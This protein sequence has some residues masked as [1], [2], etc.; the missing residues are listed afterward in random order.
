MRGATARMAVLVLVLVLGAA[1][2]LGDDPGA[3]DPSLNDPNDPGTPPPTE[4]AQADDPSEVADPSEEA[5]PIAGSYTEPFSVALANGWTL[6]DCLGERPT[7]CLWD[8]ETFVGDVELADGYPLDP[9]EDGLTDAEILAGRAESFLEH[10]REDRGAGCE[11]FAFEAD[12]VTDATVAGQPAVRAAFTLRSA[13]GTPVERV[14]N[15][16]L[17][18]G[19]GIAL[20][21]TDA[22]AAEGGC[23]PPSDV[24]ASFLPEDLLR[25]EGD[26]D[27]IVAA[28]PLPA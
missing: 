5:E 22:Y 11:G 8:G 2:C 14:V 24:D 4:D 20:V 12:E 10:F 27:R 21:T 9:H 3:N 17:R 16:F 19:D 13:D 18:H 26:L 1:G 28:T 7:M 15:H 23:L 25:F 6:R